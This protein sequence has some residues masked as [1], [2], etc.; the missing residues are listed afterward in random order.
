MLN[1]AIGTNVLCAGKYAFSGYMHVFY[2][3]MC[4]S[5]HV[6]KGMFIILSSQVHV[7]N[8]HDNIFMV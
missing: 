6:Y 5:V 2:S 4:Y 1:N 3:D 7:F 8:K